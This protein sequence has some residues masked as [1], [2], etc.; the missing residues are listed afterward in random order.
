M[1]RPT[2]L[3][4][5]GTQVLI[6]IEHLMDDATRTLP[7]GSVVSDVSA[8]PLRPADGAPRAGAYAS[9]SAPVSG[10]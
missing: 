8:D 6:Q 2:L 7:A 5:R 4:A 9:A 1:L 10:N 3:T